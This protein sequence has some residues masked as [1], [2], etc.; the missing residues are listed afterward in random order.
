M[1]FKLPSTSASS[2]RQ[3]RLAFTPLAPKRLRLFRD[4]ISNRTLRA[5]A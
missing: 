5:P 3:P 1:R 4:Q 2:I